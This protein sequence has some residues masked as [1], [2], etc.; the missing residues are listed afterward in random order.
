MSH[1]VENIK[2]R[3]CGGDSSLG[4]VRSGILS[5]GAFFVELACTSSGNLKPKP[6]IS[7]NRVLSYACKE[8]GYISQYMKENMNEHKS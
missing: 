4:D 6:G 7:N 3:E 8:C 1:I 5:F 2:C